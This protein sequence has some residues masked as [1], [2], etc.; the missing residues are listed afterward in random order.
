MFPLYIK[1]FGKSFLFFFIKKSR[2]TNRDNT[3]NNGVIGAN[4]VNLDHSVFLDG[5]SIPLFDVLLAR[6]C[7]YSNNIILYIN[8]NPDSMIKTNLADNW[9]KIIK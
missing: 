1:K 9:Y 2:T 6:G 8:K 7:I 3:R 4:D 5:K